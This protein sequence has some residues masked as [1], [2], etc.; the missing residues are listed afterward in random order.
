[1]VT[2]SLGHGNFFSGISW[3]ERLMIAFF[4]SVSARTAGFTNM[5]LSVDTISDSGLLLLMALMF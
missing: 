3:P 5:P 2:E 4:E 1:M